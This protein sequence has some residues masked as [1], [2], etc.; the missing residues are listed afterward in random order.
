MAYREITDESGRQW[1]VWDTYPQAFGGRS[2]IA[3]GYASGWL[4]FESETEKRRLA[5]VPEGWETRE[6]EALLRFLETA[7]GV[8][9]TPRGERPPP[10]TGAETAPAP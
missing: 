5:P 4:T 6:A 2:V 8:A 10:L 9:P 7:D 3:D 1:R